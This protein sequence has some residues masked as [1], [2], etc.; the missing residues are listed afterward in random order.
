LDDLL[1]AVASVCMPARDEGQARRLVA[2]MVD[3][4]RHRAGE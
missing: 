3:G 2:L 4:L 1:H